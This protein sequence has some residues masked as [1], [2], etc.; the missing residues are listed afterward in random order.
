M[1]RAPPTI[2]VA[3]AL[4][5]LIAALDIIDTILALMRPGGTGRVFGTFLRDALF[6][7]AGVFLLRRAKWA[8]WT[9]VV[10]FALSL[11]RIVAANDWRDITGVALALGGLVMTLLP[12]SRA[13]A[14]K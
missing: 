9:L 14:T 2:L 7:L 12:A 11:V 1:R 13:W 3:V 5:L 4:A 10:L 8:L 6:I